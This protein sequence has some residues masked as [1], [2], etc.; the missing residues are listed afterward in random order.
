M[1]LCRDT[2][3][4]QHVREG[5]RWKLLSKLG[6]QGYGDWD[7][8][9]SIV[10]LQAD[11]SRTLEASSMQLVKLRTGRASV[12]TVSLKPSAWEPR[13]TPIQV[14]SHHGW[15]AGSSDI[16]GQG[17][18]SVPALEGRHTYCPLPACSLGVRAS[19]IVLSLTLPQRAEFHC[20]VFSDSHT[21]LP[22]KNPQTIISGE[23]P[24]LDKGTKTTTHILFTHSHMFCS[25]SSHSL[26]PD[27]SL[28]VK[29]VNSLLHAP[30]LPDHPR[31][32][33]DRQSPYPCQA[34]RKRWGWRSQKHRALPSSQRHGITDVHHSA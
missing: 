3:A 30:Q 16:Q 18:D 26:P 13:E 14:Q 15:R 4:R 11:S 2:E 7:W 25:F 20:P 23:F 21:S 32:Q 22:R 29:Q 1:D 33:Q 31:A 19:W 34:Q 17:K 24:N 12:K 10:V 8:K 6:S 27:L 28:G 9:N 5:T